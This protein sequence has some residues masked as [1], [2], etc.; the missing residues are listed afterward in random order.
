MFE[1]KIIR[2]VLV[3]LENNFSSKDKEVKLTAILL[4]ASVTFIK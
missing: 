1:I 3:K 4:S 2:G